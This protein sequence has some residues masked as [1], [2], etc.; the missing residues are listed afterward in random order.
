MFKARKTPKEQV[1]I[2]DD[3]VTTGGTAFEAWRA[4]GFGPALVV[5]AT[6]AGGRL[7]GHRERPQS[8]RPLHMDP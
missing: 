6:S 8:T 1:V 5:T 7:S 2:V 4:L 3:V